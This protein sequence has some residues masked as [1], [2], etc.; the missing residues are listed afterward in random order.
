MS[1][2]ERRR[3][4]R[5]THP[6]LVRYRA[7]TG[8]TSWRIAPLRNLS[9]EG[10]CFRA[11]RTFQT[12]EEFDLELILPA[13]KQPIPVRARIVWSKLV[14]PALQLTEYGAQFSAMDASSRALIGKTVA[15][16][17]EKGT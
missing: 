4:P 12:G 8:D 11:E 3:F 1:G 5:L 13:D 2:E 16:F 6:F 15:S 17:L 7:S 9:V 10:V 14:N